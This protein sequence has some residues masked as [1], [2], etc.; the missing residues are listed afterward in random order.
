MEKPPKFIGGFRWQHVK[1][2]A[3]VS[4]ARYLLKYVPL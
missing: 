4:L 2:L 1:I 3:G